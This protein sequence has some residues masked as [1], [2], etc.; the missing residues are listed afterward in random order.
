[1]LVLAGVDGLSNE[2][3]DI[4]VGTIGG[5]GEATPTTNPQQMPRAKE[6]AI[7]AKPNKGRSAVCA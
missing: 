3:E 4:V 5:A 2:W 7:L 1:M 6:I